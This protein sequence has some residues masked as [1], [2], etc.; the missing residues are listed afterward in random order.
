MIYYMIQTDKIIIFPYKRFANWA[1]VLL[2]V[3]GI[4]PMIFLIALWGSSFFSMFFSVLTLLPFL[5]LYWR[6]NSYQTIVDN[7]TKTI[8]Q[9]RWFAKFLPVHFSDVGEIKFENK[10]YRVFQK[11]AR[12]TDGIMVSPYWRNKS[13]TYEETVIHQ[14]YD[15]VQKIPSNTQK[16]IFSTDTLLY[17]T[18]RH[19]LY[20]YKKIKILST[21]RNCIVI[22]IILLLAYFVPHSEDTSLIAW[23]SVFFITIMTMINFHTI[24]VDTYKRTVTKKQLWLLSFLNITYPIDSF[25]QYLVV[26]HTY[27]GI[28]THTEVK[29]LFTTLKG[30]EKSITI[31]TCYR[32]DT[33]DRLLDETSYVCGI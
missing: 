21:V 7:T 24:V 16:E 28:Y 26:R 19:W 30:K 8:Q 33:I 6:F 25:K 4:M 18:N 12:F 20:T 32:R 17:W 23:F 10:A 5:L 31:T 27:N 2:L 9:E 11:W 3:M 13:Q 15:W 14:I 22:S 1:L 29:M